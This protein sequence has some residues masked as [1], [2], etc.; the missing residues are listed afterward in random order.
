[1]RKIFLL[2]S[3]GSLCLNAQLSFTAQ[4]VPTQGP[5]QMGVVDMNGDF[6]DDIVS[7][8]NEQIQVLF[9][10]TDGTFSSKIFSTQYT[11][12]MPGWSLTAGDFNGD[13]YN[14]LMYGGGS[15]VTFMLSQVQS[16]N[17][18]YSTV[19]GG[20]Y[21]FSQRGNFI[22][23]NNDG[24]LDAYMCHDTQASV[25]YINENN[26]PVFHQG[27]LG[28]HSGG[29]H[30]G[31]I[32]VDYNNDGLMDL[33]IAKCGSTTA[34]RI[35]ELHRNNG[36]GTFTNVAPEANLDSSSENWSAAWGDF[37][38]DGW[39]D[40]FNGI[41]AQMQSDTGHH[42]LM[43]NNGDG[44]FTN[45]TVGSGF[46][47]FNGKSREYYTYDFNND[48]YL[49]I[50]GAA[51]GNKHYIFIN[52]GD[53]TFTPVEV[54][55][56]NAA[57]GDLNNDGFLDAFAFGKVYYNTGNSNNWVKLNTIGTESNRNGIGARVELYSNLGK[58]IREVRSGEG[59]AY[60]SS[61]NT[62]FGLGADT[63]IEK[64]IIRWPSG[65]V[66]T[67]NNPNINSTITVVEGETMGVTELNNTQ[68]SIYPNPVKN[69]IH[70]TGNLTPNSKVEIYSINGSLVKKS[71]VSDKKVNVSDLNKGVY[72]LVLDQNGK[73]STTKFIKQ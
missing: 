32:W 16:V 64:I 26:I 72:I 12:Y 27:G 47:Q 54:P 31:S 30:Y 6:L 66:D 73:R 19:Y 67:I 18:S 42:E 20:Q 40:L 15:G 44:T 46:D 41:N 63:E 65:I 43:K 49:D 69:N 50:G 56:S 53:M 34:K 17:V 39:L 57:I 3:L 10:N 37:D 7:V 58:Q 29:G 71:N 55:F 23:I 21:V 36:D 48:G 62:H 51:Q 52:N 70:I 35:N 9:Q 1:M 8:N 68:F 59:F 38:N 2:I 28:D 5:Y 60:M 14:D 33:F 24:N 13:G 4:S 11:P 61:L 25:Y 22:D 45:I